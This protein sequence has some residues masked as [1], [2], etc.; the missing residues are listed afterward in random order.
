MRENITK[1]T[2][3]DDFASIEN[4]EK[5]ERIE[6]KRQAMLA[7]WR[8]ESAESIEQRRREFNALV[9]DEDDD[10]KLSEEDRLELRQKILDLK[11]KHFNVDTEE[12]EN[13][14][15]DDKSGFWMPFRILVPVNSKGLFYKASINRLRDQQVG[16]VKSL[17]GEIEEAYVFDYGRRIKISSDKK[18]WLWKGEQVDFNFAVE[19][20]VREFEKRNCEKVEIVKEEKKQAKSTTK[21]FSM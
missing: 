3:A 12:A 5:D 19:K 20:L 10:G 13:K 21:G 17:N 4:N 9:D 18:D 16:Y 7:R 6:K 14:L 8:S 11:A 1:F 15:H 2:I